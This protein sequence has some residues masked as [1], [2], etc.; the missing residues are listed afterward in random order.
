[1]KVS[2]FLKMRETDLTSN[3]E[4]HP[5]TLR[6]EGHM[7]IHSFPKPKAIEC[8]SIASAVQSV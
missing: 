5:K 8:S 7:H 2:S 3:T 4:F 6:Y 1:M